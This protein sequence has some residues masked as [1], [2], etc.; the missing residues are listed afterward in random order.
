MEIDPVCGMEVD[1]QSAAGQATYDGKTYYFCSLGCQQQFERSPATY[2]QRRMSGGRAESEEGSR[3]EEIGVESGH[4]VAYTHGTDVIE[5]HGP[6]TTSHG[7][8]VVE[9][10]EPGR[11]EYTHGTDVIEGHEPDTTTYGTDVIERGEQG[12]AG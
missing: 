10:G 4:G 9:H 1:P 3:P 5:G 12:G 2:V 7:T 11:V 8:D 6:G